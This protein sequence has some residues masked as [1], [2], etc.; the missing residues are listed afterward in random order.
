MQTTQ[1]VENLKD[2]L[3]LAQRKMQDA[4]PSDV[5]FSVNFGFTLSDP[6]HDLSSSQVETLIR[7]LRSAISEFNSELRLN[8]AFQISETTADR[9]IADYWKACEKEWTEKNASKTENKESKS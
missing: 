9:R 7:K 1:T 8:M 5:K 3:D 6:I 4:F 2:I